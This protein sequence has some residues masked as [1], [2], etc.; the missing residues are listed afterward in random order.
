MVHKRYFNSI[1]AVELTFELDRPDA[2]EAAVAVD[3]LGWVAVPMRRYPRGS[4]PLKAKL[5]L[6]RDGDIEFRYLVDGSEWCNDPQADGTRANGLG[7]ENSVL[8][9]ATD[10]G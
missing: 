8:V 10:G 2:V 7:G 3:A 4:G 6:P 1:D 9:T 5:R